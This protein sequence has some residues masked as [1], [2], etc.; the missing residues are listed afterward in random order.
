MI[1]LIAIDLD[2]TLLDEQKR[3]SRKNCQIIKRLIGDQIQVVIASG[4]PYFRVK[5]I[6]QKL[7]LDTS[8]HYVVTYNG[9][10]ISLADGSQILDEKYL[11]NEEIK[12]IIN[13]LT[14]YQCCYN[15]YYQDDIYTT[16]LNPKI[17]KMKVF[18]GIKFKYTTLNTLL[19]MHKANKI[20]LADDKTIIDEIKNHLPKDLVESFNIVRST[21]NF[22]EFL[23][24]NSSKGLAIKTIAKKLNITEDEI[25]VIGDEEND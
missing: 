2:G 23:P 17:A 3:I 20:I 14:Q 11:T 10:S 9:G 19:A 16:A 1:K 4:R 12:T 5:K 22:L 6:L 24:K 7:N 21:P 25:M 18:K 8:D 13:F 15:L